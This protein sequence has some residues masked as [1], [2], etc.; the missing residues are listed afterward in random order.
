[1]FFLVGLPT[2]DRVN[3][4][5]CVPPKGRFLFFPLVNAF[6]A[7]DPGNSKTVADLWTELQQNTNVKASVL[8]A[9]VDGKEVPNLDPA[10]TPFR[11]CAGPASEGCGPAFALQL[12]GKNIYGAPEGRYDPAVADGYYLMLKPLAPGAHVI[13]F[14]GTSPATTQDIRY[15]LTVQ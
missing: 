11:A 7:N 12:P 13:T 5:E 10:S 6:N 3:R 14:G 1:M 9:S 2:S 15:E 4:T 8:H